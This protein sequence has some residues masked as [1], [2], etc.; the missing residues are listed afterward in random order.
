M[1]GTRQNK[2]VWPVDS[3]PVEIDDKLGLDSVAFQLMY[4]PSE[5]DEAGE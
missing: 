1:A 3:T 5:T 4:K 2:F